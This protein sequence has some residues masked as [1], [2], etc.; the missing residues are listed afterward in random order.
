MQH[1]TV[2]ETFILSGFTQVILVLFLL[3]IL[4]IDIGFYTRVKYFL[5]FYSHLHFFHYCDS[6]FASNLLGIEMS[7][8]IKCYI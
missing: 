7:R 4:T 8:E 5:Q 3:S 6:R 1:L 2:R